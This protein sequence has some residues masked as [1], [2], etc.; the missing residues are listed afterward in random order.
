M[1]VLKMLVWIPVALITIYIILL[2]YIYFNQTKIM[3][4]PTREF[5][6]L[7]DQYNLQYEDVSIVL[8][9]SITI[10]GWYFP[11][12][13]LSNNKTVLFCHGN[14]GNISNRLETAQYL[15]NL[16]ASVL[17]FDYRGYGKST[18]IPTEEGLYA[19]AEACYN[20]LLQTKK[21]Q[22]TDIVLFGRS[23]GGAVAV[24]LASRVQVSGL[25]VESSFTSAIDVG[26]RMFPIF[27][28]RSLIKYSF[29]SH[30]KI[31]KLSL[32]ILITH[33]PDDDLIPY[34]MGEKL[35]KAANE[36]RQFIQLSGGH[37]SLEY[38]ENIEY[39]N[40]LKFIIFGH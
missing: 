36:P 2:F 33:S 18:G 20:W 16:G 21:K 31:S 24:E 6:V 8:D 29:N 13:D 14:A 27:P 3:F 37:N 23:L 11:S 34:D 12:K 4:H 7:P 28:I 26:K 35:F 40:A 30:S 22:P 9:N 1:K 25:I 17:I 38:F 15:V 5:A 32:P 39:K 10:H 19:D